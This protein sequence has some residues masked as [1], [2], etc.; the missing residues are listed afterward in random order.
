MVTNDLPD[1][2]NTTF[3]LDIPLPGSPISYINGTKS[4]TFTV[5]TGVHL[6]SVVLPTPGDVDFINVKGSTTQARYMQ[7]NPSSENYTDVYYAFIPYTVDA[8]VVVNIVAHTAGTAYVSGVTAPLAVAALPQNPAAWQ[9][10]NQ[11]PTGVSFGNPGASAAA[12]IL[13]VRTDGL[14]Y[15]LHS[16]EWIW[17]STPANCYGQF[18]ST[19]GTVIGYD[20]AVGAGTP[21]YMNFGGATLEQNAGFEFVQTGSAAANSG[22]VQGSLTY[23]VY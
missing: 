10:P 4:V 19:A 5:P 14:S 15:W 21:R 2:S 8:S 17:N 3:Q 13:P 7:G 12:T 20:A 22:F 16:F 6:L 1:W 9:G 23:S 11:R 18:Q